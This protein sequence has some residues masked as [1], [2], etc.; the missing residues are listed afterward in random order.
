MDNFTLNGYTQEVQVYAKSY[1]RGFNGMEKDDEVKGQGNSYTTEFRQYDA[2]LGRWLSLDPLMAK[3]P[4]LSAFISYNNNPIV[5]NDIKGDIPWPQVLATFIKV[6][7]E[8]GNR[9]DPF[10]G[11]EKVG[12]GGMDIAAPVGTEVRAMASGKV[13]MVRWDAKNVNGQIRGYGRYVVIQHDNGYYSLYGH[14]EKDGVL[15]KEGQEVKD[16]D[17]IASSGNTGGS[18]GPHLHLEV[19]KA[20]K[21]NDI[22]KYSNKLNPRD[23]GDLQELI[24]GKKT[25][26][27]EEAE[28]NIDLPEI[29]VTAKK[30]T[31]FKAPINKVNKI[32]LEKDSTEIKKN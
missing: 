21:L 4:F 32:I 9:K 18:T 14:L 23:V 8:Q 29:T 3:F 22:F 6:T 13:V 15:V 19:I 17:P 20:N 12:H 1:R 25:E 10:T 11:K 7:S 30:N 16:G 2:R 26:K 24:T 31:D 28:K 5:F 27:A